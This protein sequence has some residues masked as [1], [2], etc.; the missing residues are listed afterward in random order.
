MSLSLFAALFLQ[1][2]ATTPCTQVSPPAPGLESWSADP[3]ADAVLTIGKP[4]QVAL[5][6]AADVPLGV[7][8]ERTPAPGTYAG[9]LSLSVTHAGT[10]R[11]ALS[12]GGWIDL[13]DQNGKALKSV[14]HA[15]GPACSGI[16]KIVDF[17]VAPGR[18]TL[19]V[20]GAKTTELRV[21]IATK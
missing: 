21:L 13:V 7:A 3:T 2:A 8:P 17:A 14:G 4:A 15:E 6:A 12:T 20:S 11:V 9:L 5:R 19:Q 10:Y 1:A 16:R 18:Y